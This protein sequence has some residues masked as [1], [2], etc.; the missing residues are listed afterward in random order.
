MLSF[1]VLREFSELELSGT[2]QTEAFIAPTGDTQ[3]GALGS[4]RMFVV[5]VHGAVLFRSSLPRPVSLAR[6]FSGNLNCG[7]L[8]SRIPHPA[9]PHRRFSFGVSLLPLALHGAVQDGIAATRIKWETG[10]AD[11]QRL[12]LSL[13]AIVRTSSTAPVRGMAWARI[14]GNNNIV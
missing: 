5:V 11:L 2:L 10:A 8:S 6:N 14:D 3:A 9:C 1:A 12:R 13:T 7:T 4:S